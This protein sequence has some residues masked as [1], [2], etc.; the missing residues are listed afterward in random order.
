[1]K[2]PYIHL[3]KPLV[4]LMITFNMSGCMTNV[5]P[6]KD[7]FTEQ[8]K[9]VDTIK[10]GE[11]L[12]VTNVDD[13]VSKARNAWNSGKK[14]LALAY[15]ITAFKI[16]PKNI[17]VL[18]EMAVL[19]NKLGNQE[20]ETVCY[21]MILENDPEQLAVQERYGLILIE[22]K[23]LDEAQQ[24]LTK[25]AQADIKT[26]QSQNGLGIVHDMKG[27]HKQAQEHFKKAILYHPHVNHPRHALLL[28]NFGYSLYKDKQLDAAK[29][30]FVKALKI[31]PKFKK[32]IFNY[33]LISAREKNYPE[34]VSTF[35]KAISASD[36]N[37]N[38]GYIAMMNNDFEQA[39]YYFNQAIKLSPR[40]SQKAFNNLRELDNRKIWDSADSIPIS[41]Y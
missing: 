11:L 26:W 41:S 23:N 39:D 18:K 1:M 21:R 7:E 37:N 17:N 22:Q 6:S 29:Y 9:S 15:Y 25:V 30:Y 20:L 12:K 36:A 10:N 16:E 32:S 35:S 19:Y 28:N 38:T 14:D 2:Q 40:F 8:Q 31:N 5:S 27:N 24:A 4:I 34:A 33:A 3:K 13:A